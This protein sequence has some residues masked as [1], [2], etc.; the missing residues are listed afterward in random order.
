VKP[1][2]RGDSADRKNVTV[3]RAPK[4]KTAPPVLPTKPEET[5]AALALPIEPAKTAPPA[6]LAKPAETTDTPIVPKAGDDAKNAPKPSVTN[7]Q[8]PAPE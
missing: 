3:A 1:E 5:T 2:S 4:E 7:D 8:V 6:L